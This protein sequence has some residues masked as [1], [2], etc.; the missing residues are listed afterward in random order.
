MK[1]RLRVALLSV[2]FMSGV[3]SVVCAADIRNSSLDAID[4]PE[5]SVDYVSTR[6]QSA[7]AEMLR[8][9]DEA[10]R[11][12]PDDVELAVAKC[13]FIGNFAYSEELSWVDAAAQ[14]LQACQ[15]ELQRKFP[16]QPQSTLYILEHRYGK[17]A[18]SFGEP[19]LV[20]S[21]GW[22]VAQRIRL[23]AALSRAYA[24]NKQVAQAGEQAWLT[25]QLD[26][27]HERL[28]TALRYLVSIN[29]A[30]EAE[31]LLVNAPVEK[32]MWMESARINAAAELFPGA[33]AL[34]ELQRAEH[35]GL[36]IDAWTRARAYRRA[37]DNAQAAA[38]LRSG[39][40]ATD[41]ETPE[42]RRLRFDLA[43]LAG[44]GAG[45]AKVLHDWV[46]KTGVTTQLA[47]AYA[48]LLNRHPAAALNGG[49]GQLATWLLSAALGFALLPGLLAFPAHYRGTVRARLGKAIVPLFAG[50]GLRHM[51]LAL[52]VFL[53]VG[54]LVP[55]V[56]SGMAVDSLTEYLASTVTA[57]RQLALTQLWMLLLGSLFLLYPA[58]RLT[59]LEWTGTGLW[60]VAPWILL[61]SAVAGLIFWVGS[62][63]LM[64]LHPTAQTQAVAAVITG[65][66][67]IGGI[68]FALLLVAVLVPIYE[69]F[70]FRGCILGGLSRHLSFGWANLCQA[71]IFACIHSD[72]PRFLFYLVLGLTAGWMARRTRGLVA[73]ILLHGANNGLAVL[74]LTL[75]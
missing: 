4:T 59:R 17:E 15:G 73:P 22:P 30:Q 51:W 48:N 37:G 11:A 5:H 60:R 35:A 29:K 13:V 43:L 38:A 32:M 72:P 75:L 39:P 19:L 9:F 28:V 26:P 18:I 64:P 61:W 74:A 3:A 25:V 68:P 70:V 52:G 69:E 36:K 27:G 62:L 24:A 20:R 12:R 34:T 58:S 47:Y 42:Q 53:L 14:D 21:A 65:A 55:V 50:L 45:A 44:D 23:H 7:Y 2:V 67:A 8:A 6:H 71:V 10:R 66:Q 1:M 57:Q 63:Q 16:L 40:A 33:L 49:L 54:F 56:R 41:Y 31:Q 46:R